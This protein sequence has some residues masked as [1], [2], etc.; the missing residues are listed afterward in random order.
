M[1]L[2]NVTRAAAIAAVLLCAASS[3]FAQRAPPGVPMFQYGVGT[4]SCG[5]WL[6]ERKE[7]GRY[8][9]AERREL[10]LHSLHIQWVLGWVSAAGLYNVQGP[11]RE[12]QDYE[13]DAWVEKY[14]QEHPLNKIDEAAARLV[15]ELSK[16][17]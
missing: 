5:K 4:T 1:A 2:D 16:T 15:D 17:K 9:P 12:T 8:T 10:A 6:A 3:G 13:V 7:L 11:L 14:C